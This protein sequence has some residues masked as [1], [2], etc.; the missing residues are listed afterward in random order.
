MHGEGPAG[1]VFQFHVAHLPIQEDIFIGHMHP[2]GQAKPGAESDGPRQGLPPPKL[3]WVS[4]VT[5][6]QT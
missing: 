2:E 6:Q 4:G 3:R 1:T 5:P